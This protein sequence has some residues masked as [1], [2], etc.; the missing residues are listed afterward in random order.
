[1][2][3]LFFTYHTPLWACLGTISVRKQLFDIFWQKWHTVWCIYK[4]TAAM[5]SIT[6]T[7]L[8]ITDSE[9]I[10]EK[11]YCEGTVPYTA[12]NMNLQKV[13]FFCFSHKTY[14]CTPVLLNLSLSCPVVPWNSYLPILWA[15]LVC[16]NVSIV[17][18]FPVWQKCEAV[19][20][21]STLSMSEV[22]KEKVF[23][24][25]IQDLWNDVE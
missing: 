5:M 22:P 25:I 18:Q 12:Q 15:C 17:P 3:E 14:Y 21:V 20:C 24:M 9:I 19:W 8:M 6:N 2:V 1:M 11:A 7:F 10:E 13:S 4:H 23:L 16:I